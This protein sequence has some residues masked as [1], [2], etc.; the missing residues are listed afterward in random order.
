MDD[1]KLQEKIKLEQ[2]IESLQV[3]SISKGAENININRIN[4]E[5]LNDKQKLE[6]QL[7]EASARNEILAKSLEESKKNDLIRRNENDSQLN[8]N[9]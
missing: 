4:T 6:I 1:T 5:L 8:N 3:L 7:E 9:L 2:E